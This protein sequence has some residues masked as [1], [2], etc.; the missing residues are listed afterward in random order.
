MDEGSTGL[1]KLGHSWSGCH[2]GDCGHHGAHSSIESTDAS[3][4]AQSAYQC[5][6]AGCHI[7]SD[8]YSELCSKSDMHTGSFQHTAELKAQ[9]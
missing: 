3:G 7:T 5:E 9:I 4:T 1:E 2:S 8:W 6:E